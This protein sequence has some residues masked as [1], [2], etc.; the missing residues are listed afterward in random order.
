MRIVSVDAAS[1]RLWDNYV[2]AHPLATPYHRFAWLQAVHGA[3]GFASAPLMALHNGEVAGVLPL[4]RFGGPVRTYRLV[5]LPY[6]DVGGPLADDANVETRLVEEA[7]AMARREGAAKLEIRRLVPQA[8]QTPK[9]LMRLDLP[10]GPDGAAR[11]AQLFRSF[12]AKLRSQVR[13]PQRDRLTVKAGGQEL[14]ADFYRVFARNMRDLGSPTHS[15]EWF[16]NVVRG[17]G[18]SARVTVVSLPDGTICAGAILLIHGE[19]G[20]VPWASSLRE[21]NPKNPNMLLYWDM[22][23]FACEHGLAQFD[24]GRSTPG[25]GTYRFKRQWGA[26]ELGLCWE[27][28]KVLGKDRAPRRMASGLG[29]GHLGIVARSVW[30]RLP[31]GV[32]NRV[33]PLFRRYISL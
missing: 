28:V 27:S 13:K 31:L 26:N 30:R 29:G 24:F 10:G 11:A 33:G 17:F 16:E 1:Q 5:S 20:F 18:D 21:H 9:V 23:S 6:C 15:L 12:P 22:L 32:A 3:Y 14:L 19:R 25:E 4:V 8:E 7:V 2:A